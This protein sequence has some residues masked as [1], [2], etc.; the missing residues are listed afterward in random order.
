MKTFQYIFIVLVLSTTFISGCANSDDVTAP[1]IQF[2]E[3]VATITLEELYNKATTEI[4]HYTDNDVL[5][6]YVSSSDEGGTFY[7]SVSLQNREGTLGFS[8]PVDMYNIHTYINPGRKVYIYLQDTYFAINHSSLVI[9]DL[10]QENNV[11]RMRPPDFYKKIFPSKEVLSEEEL[12]QTVTL[13]QLKNNQYINILVEIENVQFD[14]TAVGKPFYDPDGFN[15]GGATNHKLT[16]ATGSMIF[17]TSAYAS[18]ATKIV[19]PNSG[20]IRGVLNKYNN[21]F[22]FMARTFDDLKLNQPRNRESTAIGGDAMIFNVIINED[23]ESYTV[24]DSSQTSFPEYG[25]DYSFGGRYWAVRSFDHNKYIQLT[26]FGNNT[27]TKSYFIIPVYFNGNNTLSFKTKDGYYNGNVLSVYFISE[28]D[29]TYG[30]FIDPATS[31]FTNITN[32]FT[33][34]TGTTNGYADLF[35]GSGIYSFPSNTTGNG[36]IVFEYSG[37]ETVTTTIQ[38]DEIKFE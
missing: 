28:N 13:A 23:F 32:Q 31:G 37:S 34:S 17:R 7:K 35:V 25:N 33:Y 26:S 10:Y 15:I 24:S 36:Y 3:A 18:F 6:A 4:Q 22:Q 38:I 9:G 11:G 30:D 1:E 5:E 19:P 16:D 21:D 20:N 8:I 27:L 12:K 2:H 29:Y 14:D